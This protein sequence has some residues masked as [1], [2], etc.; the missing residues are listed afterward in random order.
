MVVVTFRQHY[1]S[2]NFNSQTHKRQ[3]WRMEADGS[4]RIV[5]EEIA[6]TGIG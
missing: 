1:R 4:W 2:N 3:Y 5:A 6:R